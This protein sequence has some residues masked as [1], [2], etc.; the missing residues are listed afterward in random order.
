ML[1]ASFQFSVFSF[2]FSVFSFQFLDRVEPVEKEKMDFEIE[3]D[4]FDFQKNWTKPKQIGYFGGGGGERDVYDYDFGGGNDI[5]ISH[6]SSPPER[7]RGEKDKGKHSIGNTKIGT[8][9]SGGGGGGGGGSDAMSAM[10][11]AQSMLNKYSGKGKGTVGAVVKKTTAPTRNYMSSEYNED[12]IS[13]GSDE[14]SESG[15]GFSLDS[16]PEKKPKS[17]LTTASGKQK[18]TFPSKV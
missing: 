14:M 11:K 10:E 4:E 15:A 12:D 5:E 9:S 2:Q 17:Q 13:I 8:K 7:E 6:Y 18:P 3:D 1:I 16:S